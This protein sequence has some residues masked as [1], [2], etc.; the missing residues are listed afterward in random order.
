MKKTGILL[1]GLLV[2]QFILTDVSSAQWGLGAAVEIRDQDPTTGVGI[3]LER[4]ILS[5]APIIDLNLRGHFSWFYDSDGNGII[6]EALQSELNVYDYGLALVLGVKLG[7]VKPY[8]GGGIGREHY[9]EESG[10]GLLSHSEDN[11]YWNGFGGAEITLLPYLKPFI[12][13]RYSQL[14]DIDEIRVSEYNRLSFGLT[15]RF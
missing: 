11:F 10:G 9:R 6:D 12:E 14:T 2:F 8:I 13:F 4:E 3:K 5:K 7:L 1:I 15:F